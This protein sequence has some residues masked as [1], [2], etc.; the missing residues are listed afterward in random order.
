MPVITIH[1]SAADIERL[2]FGYSPLVELSFSFCTMLGSTC[3]AEH[4]TW[5]DE[6]RRA[7]HGF[8]LPYMRAV[9][10][11]YAY[12]ADFVTPPPDGISR[13]LEEEFE[14]MR[15]TPADVIR[16]N[17]ETTLRH[18]APVTNEYHHFMMYPHEA[19]ECLIEELRFYWQR[20]LE[21][22]WPRINSALE[23]DILYRARQMALHGP[24]TMLSDLADRVCY[25]AGQLKIHRH[26]KYAA[27]TPEYHLNGRG[28]LFAPSIFKNPEGISWQIVPE[29]EPMFA[30][31]ARGS[32]LWYN[33]RRPDP[34][35]ELELTLGAARARLLLA[36]A[37][38][39]STT[40][41]GVKLHMTAGAVSQQLT[42]L[43]KAKLVESQ[44]SG[45]KVYYRL[46][47]RGEKLLALFTE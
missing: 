2:H 10:L 31:G 27:V 39:T 23:Q 18:D 12:L 29:W 30:Y 32:G 11:P 6:A 38:P 33:A 14:R 40:E 7:L 20:T 1:L 41:L 45:H 46:T 13:S 5:E 28:L 21:R 34:A 16:K 3:A 15:H 22:H 36:L 4:R 9:V 24:E 35:K 25:E 19:L 47:D 42:R 26:S 8:E 44:R 17:L 37:D 43:R